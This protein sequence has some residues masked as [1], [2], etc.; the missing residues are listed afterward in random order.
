F[1]VIG[2]AFGFVGAAVLILLYFM[3]ISK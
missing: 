1:S 3:L 2:E